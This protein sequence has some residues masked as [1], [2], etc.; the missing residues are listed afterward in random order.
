MGYVYV[1]Q[2]SIA[3]Q[4]YI[5]FTTNLKQRVADHNRNKTRATQRRS[6]R[7]LLIYTEVY[8]NKEDAMERE[9]RLKHYGSA[10]HELLKRIKRCL[11]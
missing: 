3:K 8:R 9:K 6:G 4:I 2:H 11:I 1:I 7:W 10:K 5:G